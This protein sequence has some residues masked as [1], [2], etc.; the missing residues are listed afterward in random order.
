MGQH[1]SDPGAVERFAEFIRSRGRRNVRVAFHCGLPDSYEVM[2]SMFQ[3]DGIDTFSIVPLSVAEG[4][5]TIWLMPKKLTLPDNSGSWTMIGEHDVATRF[6]TALNEDPVM[7][8][9]IARGLSDVPKDSM[10]LVL[11]RGSKLSISRRTARYYSDYLKNLGWNT[12]VA[13]AAEPY[14]NLADVLREISGSGCGSVHV[15]P[16]FISPGSPTLRSAIDRINDLKIPVTVGKTVSEYPEYFE[17]LDSKI[18]K[19]W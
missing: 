17:I 12:L 9:A 3:D 18:P 15:V 11:I 7:A 14:S 4:S 2:K 5:K 8:E 6:A 16:M 1:S 10:I 19:D 13:F